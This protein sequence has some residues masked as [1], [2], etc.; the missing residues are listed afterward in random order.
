MVEAM[1]RSRFAF[2]CVALIASGCG[3]NVVI[4]DPSA[5][6]SGAAGSSG[7]GGSCPAEDAGATPAASCHNY[8]D[9]FDC[10]GCPSTAAAC[11]T[12]CDEHQSNPGGDPSKGACIACAAQHI[13]ALAPMLSCADTFGW[14]PNGVTS[15][16]TVEFSASDCPVC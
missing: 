16:F 1:H 15:V 13:S 6:S 12:A 4:V 2:F 10:L 3:S 7:A 5:S 8:C 9:I 14:G 11:E